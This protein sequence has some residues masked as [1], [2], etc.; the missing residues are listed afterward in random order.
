MTA[1]IRAELLKLRTTRMV[2]GMLAGTLALVALSV[3]ST[4][5]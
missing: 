2:Y 4:A 5:S 1:A 3:V